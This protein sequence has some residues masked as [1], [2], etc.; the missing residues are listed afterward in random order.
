MRTVWWAALAVVVSV[1]SAEAQRQVL[2]GNRLVSLEGYGFAH[3][4]PKAPVWIVELA[5]FGCGYCEKF[6]KETLPVLDSVYTRTGRVSWRFVPFVTGM[7]T[8]AT[9]AVEASVCAAEQGKFW[10]MHDQLYKQRK[11]WMASRGPRQFFARMAQQL[12]LDLAKFGQCAKSKETAA[13]V[14]K[15]NALAQ[16]IGVRGTPTFVINGE[17]VPG[18]LPTDVFVKG[19]GAVY[20]AATQ[21]S[22]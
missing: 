6:A 16:A 9:E 8:N 21:G 7:F 2:V 19:L 4:N 5:D 1:S 11:A 20:Q 18:A 14:A 12:G 17:I 3:G 15:N 22:R 10:P 13:T